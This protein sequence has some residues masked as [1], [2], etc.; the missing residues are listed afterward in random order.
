MQQLLQL[1]NLACRLQAF[2]SSHQRS[3]TLEA[4]V[5]RTSEKCLLLLAL[6]PHP[7][8]REQE[9]VQ[10]NDLLHDV[11]QHDLAAFCFTK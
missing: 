8:L 1:R 6:Q 3:P 9:S 7:Q 11:I 5:L 4:S 10:A 2:L